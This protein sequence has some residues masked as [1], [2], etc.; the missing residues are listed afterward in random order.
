LVADRGSPPAWL[1]GASPA[2][3]TAFLHSALS[4]IH[5]RALIWEIFP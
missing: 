3:R 1:S 5:P 4:G 2:S